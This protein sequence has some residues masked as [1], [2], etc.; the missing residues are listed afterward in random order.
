MSTSFNEGGKLIAG[1]VSTD[2]VPLAADTYY[3]GMILEYDDTG[4]VYQALASG[5]PAAIYNGEDGRVLASAG[6]DDVIVAGE[7]ADA[8]LVDASGDALAVTE[9][10]RAQLRDA[11]FYAKRS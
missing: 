4:D 9:D 8:G 10:L 5:T 6:V 3:N 1:F 11:G 2:Q 7:V